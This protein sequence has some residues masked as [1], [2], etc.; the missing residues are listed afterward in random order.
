MSLQRYVERLS[1]D[2]K[3]LLFKYWEPVLYDLDSREF[4]FAEAV[5]Y[6]DIAIDTKDKEAALARARRFDSLKS[7][8]VKTFNRLSLTKE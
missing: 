1:E 3:G 6:E 5:V 2:I 4:Q 7:N 8:L